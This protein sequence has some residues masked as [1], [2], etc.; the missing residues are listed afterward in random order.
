[1]Q[2]TTY[3]QSYSN[4]ENDKASRKPRSSAGPLYSLIKFLTRYFLM[5]GGLHYGAVVFLGMNSHTEAL[6]RLPSLLELL[7]PPALVI[8]GMVVV[9]LTMHFTNARD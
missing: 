8:L 2:K 5:I 1:M 9:A 6:E 7:A 4:N 3:S